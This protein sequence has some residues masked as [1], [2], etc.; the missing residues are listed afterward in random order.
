MAKQYTY[1]EDAGH[2]WMRVPLQPLLDSRQILYM[3]DYS[4]TDGKAWVYL[5]E[6]QDMSTFIEL[7]EGTTWKRVYDGD[8]SFI[9]ELHGIKYLKDWVLEQETERMQHL[10]SELQRVGKELQ[11]KRHD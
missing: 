5:E 9:R 2:G 1:H 8:R 10:A 4:Y 11:E 6:D 7:N 3:S